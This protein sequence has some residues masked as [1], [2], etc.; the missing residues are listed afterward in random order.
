MPLREEARAD[1]TARPTLFCD[2]DSDYFDPYPYSFLFPPSFSFSTRPSISVSLPSSRDPS[3]LFLL[4]PLCVALNP[5]PLRLPLRVSRRQYYCPFSPGTRERNGPSD[6]LSS[7]R[8]SYR[9]AIRFYAGK[10]GS[11]WRKVERD[12][13]S[14]SVGRVRDRGQHFPRE[15]TGSPRSV[16]HSVSS[17]V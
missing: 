8:V 3:T 4:R 9:D 2:C 13:A 14:R 5:F 16:Y 10:C 15:G 6:Q 11:E 12:S 1:A 7:P 17:A